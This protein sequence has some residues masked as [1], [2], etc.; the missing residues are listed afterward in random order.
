MS[1]IEVKEYAVKLKGE[2]VMVVVGKVFLIN[3]GC[4]MP[5]PK[6]NTHYFNSKEV[7]Y[8]SEIKREK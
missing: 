7:V 4:H 2:P 6:E 8:I 3:E 5:L 1:N